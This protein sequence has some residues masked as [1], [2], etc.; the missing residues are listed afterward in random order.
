MINSTK[1]A[2][3]LMFCGNAQ[4]QVLP[5][6][7]VYKA[8]SMWTTWTEN[9]S[10]GARYNRTKSG[11][12]DSLCFEDWFQS[13]LL[14]RLKKIPGKHVVIGDNLSSH[15]NANV[16]E[17]CHQN[18]ISFVALPANSTHLTQPLDVAYFR[19][20]KVVWRQILTNWKEKGKGRKAPS[21]PRDEFPRLLKTLVEKLDNK[22]ADNLKAGF[23][24]SGIYPLDK[25]QVL[26]WLPDVVA[27]PSALNLEEAVGETFIS[28]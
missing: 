27:T 4:G 2:T 25:Q 9:G 20:M 10:Q 7:V 5:P 19:P 3:S 23:Q 8:E 6:Y 13:M 28:L 12:F 26:A 14:P 24:K 15:I 17:L 21:L 11:W 1:T 16:L 22:G 18:N